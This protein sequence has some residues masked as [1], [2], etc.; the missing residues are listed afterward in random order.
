MMVHEE[1][2]LVKGNKRRKGIEMQENGWI[3]IN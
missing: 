1:K 3:W 2:F